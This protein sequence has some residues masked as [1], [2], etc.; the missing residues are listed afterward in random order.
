MMA[1]SALM[2]SSRSTLLFANVIRS[3]NAFVG[4]L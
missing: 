1:S 2:I 3:L 4:G